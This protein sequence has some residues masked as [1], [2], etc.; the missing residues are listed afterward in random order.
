MQSRKE[1]FQ[2]LLLL[3]VNISSGR[4]FMLA[5]KLTP[6]T[7]LRAPRSPPPPADR[8]A[9]ATTQVKTEAPRN[10]KMGANTKRSWL[11]RLLGV[12]WGRVSLLIIVPPKA[13][14]EAEALNV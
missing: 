11:V 6:T 12:T 1:N 8:W 4:S 7:I 5:S 3:A 2:N 10:P 13:A 14:S 9:S